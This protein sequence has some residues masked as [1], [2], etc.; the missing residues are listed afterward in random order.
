MK[1]NNENG[2]SEN[3]RSTG[4]KLVLSSRLLKFRLWDKRTQKF[5]TS[6]AYLSN[7][8]LELDCIS[9]VKTLQ[10]TG[11]IDKNGIEIFEGDIVKA[12]WHWEDGK[13]VDLSYEG[14]FFYAIQEYVLED[15]LEV[16]GN[17]FEN[18]ELL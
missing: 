10:F 18:P 6:G 12:D 15:V 11:L 14:C 2:S 3:E 16:I 8:T 17:I 9:D 4:A 5:T 7:T 1:T 13:I